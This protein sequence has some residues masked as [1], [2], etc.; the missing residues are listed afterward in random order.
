MNSVEWRAVVGLGLVYALRMVGMFM[1]LP[2]F[3]LY[4]RDLPGGAMPVTI[5]LAIGIYGLAQAGLQI[6]LGLLSDK[7]GRKPVIYLGMIVF[8]LGSLVAGLSDSIEG[9][10]LGR[11]LQGAGAVSSAVS[12]L[13]ADVTREQVRTTA[14]AIMG[15]GMGMAFIIALVSGPIVAGWIGVDG[16][17]FVTAVLALMT[18]PLIAF[19]V[20]TPALPKPQSGGFGI[21]LRDPELLR[22]NAGIFILH[23]L[24]TALFTSA[25]IAIL[26]TMGLE[27]MEHWKVY[28][29]VLVL[30]V[31]PVFP[32]IRWAERSG[33]ARMVFRSA[34]ALLSIAMAIAALGHAGVT[35]LLLAL[36]LFFVAFNYLEG[37]LPSMISRRAP[38]AA[39]GAAMGVYASSQF[40]GAFA[41][42]ALGGLAQMLW[43]LSGAFAVC[44]VL[45]VIWL[46]IPPAARTAEI[47]PAAS[48]PRA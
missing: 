5:G 2:V 12:A 8:A 41:G 46:L 16:I 44:A 13:L 26:D 23:A 7:I 47:S 6:P 33:R 30:S 40:L 48:T 22:L 17:F 18:L 3:A 39:R 14:M 1:I 31:L 24:M 25:P 45:P 34:V 37:A 43:G 9:I 11:V 19:G 20:P 42:G 35:G 28:L 32:L 21:A 10:I 4:A 29:P 15:M 38:S 27:S 36:L